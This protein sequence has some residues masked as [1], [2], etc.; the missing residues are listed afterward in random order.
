[1]TCQKLAKLEAAAWMTGARAAEAEYPG[2]F[3]LAEAEIL[4]AGRAQLDYLQVHNVAM[5]YLHKCLSPEGLLAVVAAGHTPDAYAAHID[6]L[7]FSRMVGVIGLSCK[8]RMTQ[9]VISMDPTVADVLAFDAAAPDPWVSDNGEPLPTELLGRLPFQTFVLV[10]NVG[11]VSSYLVECDYRNH[12]GAEGLYLNV[13]ARVPQDDGSVYMMNGATILVPGLS[14]GDAITRTG[15]LFEQTVS[16]FGIAQ[17]PL[18]E[19]VAQARQ[20]LNRAL[21]ARVMPYLL[22]LC[23]ENREL[24]GEADAP[25]RIVKTKRG[26]RVFAPDR[27]R[28]LEAGIRVGAAIRSA[29]SATATGEGIGGGGVI[30]PHLRKA[31]WHAYWVGPRRE[32]HRRRKTIHFLPPIPVNVA[33]MSDL[34]PVIRPV[35]AKT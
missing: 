5:S 23:A 12:A 18:S 17:E 30:P 22:Y 13:L 8:Y 32:A 34:Q 26:L 31:H 25:L 35:D 20:L 7:A 15:A 21:L 14:L 19:N 29:R 16:T 4:K 11:E 33:R 9:Q 24:D 28:V 1:M 2:V 27:P 6:R 10:P 3:A